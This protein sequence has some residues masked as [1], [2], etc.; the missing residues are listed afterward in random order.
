MLMGIVMVHVS[1][2]KVCSEGSCEHSAILNF[3]RTKSVEVDVSYRACI[4]AHSLYT[5]QL[6]RRRSASIHTFHSTRACALQAHHVCPVRLQL[7][8]ALRAALL[9]G[10]RPDAA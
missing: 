9:H 2:D 1:D 4:S 7:R 5:C 3:Y 6:A 8:L 10:H